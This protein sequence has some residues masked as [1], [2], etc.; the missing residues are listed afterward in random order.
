MKKFFLFFLLLFVLIFRFFSLRPNFPDGSK[1]RITD[2]KIRGEPLRFEKSQRI[3]L[4]G[5]RIYL[6]LYPE[7]NYGDKITIEGRVNLKNKT[8]D[9]AKLIKVKRGDLFYNFREKLVLFY[10]KTL[11][12]PH[13]SLVAGMVLGSKS[14]LPYSFWEKLKKTGTAHVV[15]AS[16]MNVTLIAGFLLSFFLIF[17]KRR[18]ALMFST[19]GIWFYAFLSGFDAPIIRASIMGTLAFVALIL[20]RMNLALRALLISFSAMLIFNPYY[21]FDVGFILSFAATLSLILF[22]KKVDS[23]LKFIP[24]FLREGFSTSLAAQILVAPILYFTF[25]YFSIYSPLVNGLVL[26]TVPYITIFGMIAG[27]FSFFF[28]F[29][30]KLF[31]F[32]SYPL[33]FWFVSIV[34]IFSKL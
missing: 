34:E 28:P 14:S 4:L 23:F 27:I 26:W 6:P 30:A 20:G 21:L 33:T 10:Q 8:L 11:P 24:K 18:Y 29:L 2:E 25:G 32:L 9:E 22:G 1:I 13:S 16:G 15:V 12:E 31:L 7:I 3:T 5:L 19:F 17:L